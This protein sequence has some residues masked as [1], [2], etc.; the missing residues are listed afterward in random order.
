MGGAFHYNGSNYAVYDAGGFVRG[1]V[2]GSDAGTS[3]LNALTGGT[4]AAVNVTPATLGNL[5]LQT[6][7]LDGAGVNINL[8]AGAT[9]TLTNAGGLLKA[10]GGTSTISGGAGLATTAGEFV[11]RTDVA[12][13]NILLN[14]SLLGNNITVVK[15]VP[16]R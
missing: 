10:G 15:T 8:S 9:L 2:Y 7:K 11:I 6:L 3:L 5:S 14:T 16:A 12:S 1:M 4:H 13:D